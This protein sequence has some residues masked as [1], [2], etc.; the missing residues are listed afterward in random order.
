MNITVYND[1]EKVF[2]GTLAEFL[3][4]NDNEE[5]L[6]EQCEQLNTKN[7]IEFYEISGHWRVVKEVSQ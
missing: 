7:E 3:Q 1:N 5:W 2:T 6:T 4:D